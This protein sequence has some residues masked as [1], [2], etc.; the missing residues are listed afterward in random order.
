MA[1]YQ[2]FIEAL[3]VRL[4]DCTDTELVTMVEDLISYTEDI[5]NES[6]IVLPPISNP[7]DTSRGMDHPMIANND[8]VRPPLSLPKDTSKV[9]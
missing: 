4:S 5:I 8:E 7:G 3:R 6:G 2:E 9:S 1:T